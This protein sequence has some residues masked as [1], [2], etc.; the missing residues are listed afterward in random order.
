M[1]AL[2]KVLFSHSGEVRAA[3]I[4]RT[5]KSFGITTK[6]GYHTGDNATS[7]DILLIGLFRSLKL[8]FGV[9][10]HYLLDEYSLISNRLIMIQLHTAYAALIIFLILPFKPFSL[11]PQKKLSKLPLRLLKRRKIPIL[12]NYSL[13]ILC[14]GH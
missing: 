1:L 8:E 6:L 14:A 9:C 4:L 3:I 10:I 12:T 2:P 7:N 13:L 11:P 5:L